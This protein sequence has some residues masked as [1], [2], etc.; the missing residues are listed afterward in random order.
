ME[1]RLAMLGDSIAA[2]QGAARPHDNIGRRLARGLRRDGFE[3]RPR[4]FARSGSRSSGLEQQV[5]VALEWEPHLAVVVVGANDVTNRTPPREAAADLAAAVRRLRDCGAEVVVAPAPDLSVVP[6][7]PGFLRGP[8][9]AASARLRRAQVEAAAAAGARIADGDG[10]TSGSFG[11]DPALFS[12][13]RFH[14]SSAG[15]ALI[16][17]E[18]LPHVLA[19]A[20]ELSGASG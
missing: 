19:A 11:S 16:A 20:R 15:Y 8:V 5:D 14:P 12:A 9:R 1:L 4:I 3:A 6:Q 18:L 13:D 2:G 7:V 17:G 10:A